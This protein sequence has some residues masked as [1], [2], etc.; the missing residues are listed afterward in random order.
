MK[1]EYD[2]AKWLSGEMTETERNKF[3]KLPEFITYS[4]IA[5]YAQQLEKPNFDGDAMLEEILNVEKR[6]VKIV[7][8]QQT[9]FFRIACVLVLAF[10]LLFL[11][12]NNYSVTEYSQNGQKTTFELPDD[13]Q[14]VLNSDSKIEYKKWNWNSK[15][16]LDLNGEAFFKV[17]KGKTFDVNT[18]LG[19]VTVVGT[20]F[21]VKNRENRLEVECFEGKVKVA[22]ANTNHFIKKGEIIVIENNKA[23]VASPTNGSNPSWMNNE[24]RI[25]SMPFKQ[26]LKELEC[27]YDFHFDNNN[28]FSDK[29]FTGYLPKDDFKLAMKILSSTY[30]FK[31]QINK[32]TV[33]IN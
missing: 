8:F 5:A 24:I 13:S 30:Q 21:N 29:K 11:A 25:I 6:K 27:N 32:K 10:G 14:V 2:L 23:I 4:K 1:N 28:S 3:E 20:Q 22:V 33:K 17:K 7:P 19:K 26:I 16:S 15:R 18:N 31:F 12:K 9:W